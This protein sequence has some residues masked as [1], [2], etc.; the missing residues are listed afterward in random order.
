MKPK[1]VATGAK[2]RFPW[3]LSVRE[4]DKPHVTHRCA[5]PYPHT[6]KHVC[7]CGSEYLL[8]KAKKEL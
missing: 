3:F 2:C 8:R 4:D 5:L 6:G 1:K 7:E